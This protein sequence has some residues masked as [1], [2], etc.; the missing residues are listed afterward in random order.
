MSYYIQLDTGGGNSNRKHISVTPYFF[1]F[2]LDF[3]AIQCIIA[4]SEYNDDN[5]GKTVT[6]N[7]VKIFSYIRL[8]FYGNKMC[9]IIKF[10]SSPTLKLYQQLQSGVCRCYRFLIYL[11]GM[12]EDEPKHMNPQKMHPWAYLY[13]NIDAYRCFEFSEQLLHRSRSW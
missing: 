7:L 9:K 13:E 11:L 12:Y 10:S 3:S 4:I 2:F 5:Y 1:E 6:P 8:T